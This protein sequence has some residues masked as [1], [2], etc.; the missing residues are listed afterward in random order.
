MRANY[1]LIGAGMVLCSVP[2]LTWSVEDRFEEFQQER[3][4]A[5]ED[6]R[7]EFRESFQEFQDT[8]HE[9]FEAYQEE[10]RSQWEDPQVSDRHRWVEYSEDQSSRSVVDY[11][12]NEI[13]VDVPE[14]EGAEGLMLKFDDLLNRT[15]DEAYEGDEVTQRTQE[16]VDLGD[17]APTS[18][19]NERV[20]NEIS[21]EDAERMIE[22]AEVEEREEPKGDDS[23]GV[24]SMSVPMPE[25]R[26]S[27]KA[28][29]YR[30]Q[31]ERE[32]QEYGV[33]EA[34][35]MAIMHSES[36][37]N[38]MARS[39]IPAYG[40]MQIVPETAGKDIAQQVYGE[41]RLLSPDYLYNA[42]NNI[43]AG[44]A[45]L[46]ILES[47]HLS[48]IED[49]ESRMYAVI[50]AY[51]TGAGNVA[52]TFVDGT[53]VAEAAEVINSM[54]PEEVYERMLEDLPYEETRN[55]LVNVASRTEAYREF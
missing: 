45:Y 53:N 32:A 30:A 18:A 31:I 55:Y 25:K 6:H 7:D 23:R 8:F 21:P 49:P 9:E 14:D 27:D 16:K 28:E 13:T 39:H 29:E 4:Q 47:S 33:D 11:E 15:M 44:A 50:A 20:L 38:P 36:S 37:F 10:L 1:I 19:G 5:F 3:Q 17:G 42:E 52:R 2:I 24:I 41:P 54:E 40:L 51:N 46:D 43:Q 26:P 22:K 34:L 12:E 48:S 35:M